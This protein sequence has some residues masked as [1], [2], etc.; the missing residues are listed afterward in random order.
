MKITYIISNINSQ[1]KGNGGHYYS[2]LSTISMLK[3]VHEIKIINIGTQNSI[4]FRNE[5]KKIINIIDNKLNNFKLLVRL[6]KHIKTDQPHVLHAFDE[7]AYFYVRIISVLLKI[8]VIL[9]KCGGVNP[10]Y[11]Y[12]F[13]KN[14]IIYSRENLNYFKAQRR[15]VNSIIY[16]I[17][18]RILPFEN[19]IVRIS[20]LQEK[21]PL[22]NYRFI[23]LRIGRI[24]PAYKKSTIELIN[25]VE[26]CNKSNLKSCLLLIGIIE[27]FAILKE[28]Q[29]YQKKNVFIETDNYYTQN[30][31]E[32]IDIADIVLGTGRSLMEAA[33]KD[34]IILAPVNNGSN[35]VLV[36]DNNFEELFKTNF[37]ERGLLKNFDPQLEINKL[38]NIIEFPDIREKVIKG[39]RLLFNENFNL[40]YALNTY[41]ELYNSIKFKYSFKVLDTLLNYI[42]LIIFFRAN[43]S[44]AKNNKL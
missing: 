17:P 26:E 40:E 3:N 20:E 24:G 13:C 27:D 11:F 41:N 25:V 33:L 18:N 42:F 7:F 10:K 12:P 30:A 43:K 8:P 44:I 2:L 1:S 5:G 34:K 35:I 4:A 31:K 15:Y 39:N 22:R 16:L 36:D 19:D 6:Y 9:T 29:S 14:F 28:I 32:L 23:F 37:S 21:F 38:I